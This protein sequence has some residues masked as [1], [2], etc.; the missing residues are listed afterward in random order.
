MGQ[1]L[2]TAKLSLRGSN[3]AGCGEDCA[4]PFEHCK[5]GFL[6]GKPSQCGKRYE[7]IVPDADQTPQSMSYSGKP[8]LAALGPDAIL[9]F[10][11]PSLH[12]DLDAIAE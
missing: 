8:D 6:I 11:A 12:P 1:R 4:V 3:W 2:S 5:A 7:T 9:D 10:E